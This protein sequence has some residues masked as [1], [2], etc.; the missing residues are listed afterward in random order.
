MIESLNVRN[1][2]M[3]RLKKKVCI[4][5]FDFF[6]EPTSFTEVLLYRHENNKVTI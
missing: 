3:I 1:D 6:I 4:C 2:A 5:I